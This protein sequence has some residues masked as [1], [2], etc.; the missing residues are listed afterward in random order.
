MP[1]RNTLLIT[2]QD[3][4]ISCLDELGI[5]FDL[6]HEDNNLF[7]TTA[8]LDNYDNLLLFTGNNYSTY[9][10]TGKIR[11]FL[12]NGSASERNNV[13]AM[14]ISSLGYAENSPFARDLFAGTFT[15]TFSHSGD[16][17]SGVSQ[18]AITNGLSLSIS[19]DKPLYGISATSSDSNYTILTENGTGNCVGVKRRDGA[20]RTILLTPNFWDLTDNANRDSLISK[21]ITWLTGSGSEVP[22]PIRL[23]E[24]TAMYKLGGVE[25]YWRTETETNHQYT[26]IYRDEEAVIALYRQGYP[27]SSEPLEYHYT[28]YGVIPG[29]TYTYMLADMDLGNNET[30]HEDMAVTITLLDALTVI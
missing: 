11:T 29:K 3:A 2:E 16:G 18:D 9:L 1:Y 22:T 13:M 24:F 21:A 4:I 15:S 7:P 8:Q 10:D 6:Y 19:S 30:R 25:L 17:I 27:D 20:Y 5:Q 28:D 14:G 23:S 12:S 26:T